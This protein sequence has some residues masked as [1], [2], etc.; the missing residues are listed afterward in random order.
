MMCRKD[1]NIAHVE[2]SHQG[3]TDPDDDSARTCDDAEEP[4]TKA[5]VSRG[6]KQTSHRPDAG[7]LRKRLKEYATLEPQVFKPDNGYLY[8]KA[9]C[10][11]VSVES[12]ATKRHLRSNTHKA[13]VEKL[14][15]TL[16]AGR[17]LGKTLT[18]HFE[19]SN[20]AQGTLPPQQLTWRAQ[21]VKAC[22]MGGIP[23][24]KLAGPIKGLL[25]DGHYS[26]TSASHM[27]EFIPPLLAEEKALMA[28]ELEGLQYSVIF[29]ST[30]NVDECFA[31]VI[32]YVAVCVL[33][34][35]CCMLHAA[36]ACQRMPARQYSITYCS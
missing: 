27:A 32:R 4:L 5:T 18:E 36:F 15:Q 25:E 24:A 7:K 13:S 14:K 23:I 22:L 17:T 16:Q 10:Y 34:R 33:S 3:S 26:L 12:S 9:C 11:T 28:T 1:K 35:P 19:H 29:D 21:C 6:P 2:G 30:T 20:A 31:V 8:C